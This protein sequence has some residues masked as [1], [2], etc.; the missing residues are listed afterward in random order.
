MRAD[1]RPLA[2]PALARHPNGLEGPATPPQAL[3]TI[4]DRAPDEAVQML[5]ASRLRSNDHRGRFLELS[6]LMKQWLHLQPGFL[7][8]ELFE[9]ETGWIDTMLWKDRAS[10]EIANALFENTHLAYGFAEIVEPS[11]Q[12]YE[13]IVAPLV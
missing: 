7:R 1:R 9:T 4:M 3:E 5:V 8:Y 11:Y 2:S 10:M 13:G 6:Q 12:S